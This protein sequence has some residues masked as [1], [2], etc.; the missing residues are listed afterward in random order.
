MPSF[1]SNVVSV[2][3]LDTN[4]LVKTIGIQARGACCVYV[5]PD[6]RTVYNVGGLSAFITAFDTR[7]LTVSHVIPFEGT[8]GD[9]GSTMPADGRTFW[10][11][12]T[13]D[14][15][16][17]DTRTDLVT[18]VFKGTGGLFCN[19]TDGRWL[20]EDDTK[21]HFIVRD[22][23]TGAIVASTPM[24]YAN[25][26]AEAVQVSPDGRTAYIVGASQLPA[27]FSEGGSELSS[28]LEVVNV[29]DPLSP[30]FVKTVP[31]GPFPEVATFTPDGRQL[32]A[33]NS[34]DGT[35]TV[36]DV[37][38]GRVVH[39]LSTG[40]FVTNVTF[41]GDRAY[42]M[43]N[44]YDLPPNYA[45]AFYFTALAVVPGAALAPT[46]GSTAYRP[47]VDAPGQLVVYDRLTYRP[48]DI[49]PLPLP[50][51]AF[52]SVTVMAPS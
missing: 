37:A 38:T 42:I 20:F 45:T 18:R 26:G 4:K 21:G 9:H 36:V 29:S 48:L 31:T 46:S 47:V 17:L 23:A 24:P 2:F 5:S 40:R 30:Q 35:I 22:A 10:F 6:Q 15:L 1:G 49:P 16:G 3:D 51:E 39:K 28:A 27:E 12:N 13:S 34:G 14:I 8:I 7:T 50:S 52:V 32:W 41:Y 33:P 44:P 19:S 25:S 11:D 43:E